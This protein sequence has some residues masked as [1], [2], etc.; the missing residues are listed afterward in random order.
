MTSCNVRR[1]RTTYI[2]M[3]YICVGFDTNT[4]C[5]QLRYPLLSLLLSY[6][7]SSLSLLFLFLPLLLP[8]LDPSSF[9]SFL[10]LYICV[11]TDADVERLFQCSGST[12]ILTQIPSDVDAMYRHLRCLLPPLSLPYLSSSLPLIFIFLLL[13]S[14]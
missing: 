8:F 12:S 9:F 11:N 5:R 2:S 13:L 1:K 14:S 4:K 10:S 6:L 3:L 7:S